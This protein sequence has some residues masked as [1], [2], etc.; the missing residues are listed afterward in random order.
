MTCGSTG[1]HLKAEAS[2]TSDMS[3][4]LS[5]CVDTS[6]SYL[7]FF[8]PTQKHEINSSFFRIF[9][10]SRRHQTWFQIVIFNSA[11]RSVVSGVMEHV[12]HGWVAYRLFLHSSSGRYPIK[13][14]IAWW[15]QKRNYIRSITLFISLHS[16]FPSCFVIAS[17]LLFLSRV[18]PS[19]V[20]YSCL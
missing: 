12:W 3:A 18:L 2:Y 10:S 5:V 9:S 17:P 6:G 15:A 4:T 7:F 16:V 11:L 19:C 8:I 20:L 13:L 1:F 14:K